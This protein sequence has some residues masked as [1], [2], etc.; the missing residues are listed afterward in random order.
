MHCEVGTLTLSR[1]IF[2]PVCHPE[3]LLRR[4][5]VHIDCSQEPEYFLFSIK[6]L[7]CLHCQA[8][9]ELLGSQS[10]P[11]AF[12]PVELARLVSMTTF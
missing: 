12:L 1:P 2:R 5:Y 9:R 4:L 10:G 8:Y 11:R 6:S 7:I 3:R